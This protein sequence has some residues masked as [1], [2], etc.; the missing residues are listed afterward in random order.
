[1]DPGV[2]GVTTKTKESVFHGKKASYGYIKGTDKKGTLIIDEEVAPVVVR[3]FEMYASGISPR[4]IS[5]I[6]NEENVP[7]LGQYAFYGAALSEVTFPKTLKTIGDYAFYYNYT[8]TLSATGTP[9]KTATLKEINFSEGLT[10]IGKYAFYMA[11][12]ESLVMPASLTE[13]GECA[14]LGCSSLTEV[15]FADGSTKIG[16]KNAFQ[17]KSLEKVTFGSGDGL[18]IAAQTFY[19]ATA[20][21]EVVFAENCTI[22]EMGNYAFGNI[23][24]TLAPH[25]KIAGEYLYGSRRD[26]SDASGHAHR[27]NLMIQYSF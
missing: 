11:T 21:K 13:Y 17:S 24:Y 27:I 2:L 9:A 6:L 14:F 7:C 8:Q 3:I 1:M 10:G 26:M 19:G 15:T 25:C 4:R 5:E 16:G 20:L 23:F 18:V 22:K 12:V